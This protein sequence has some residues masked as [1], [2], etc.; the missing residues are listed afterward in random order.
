MASSSQRVVVNIDGV[1]YA[2]DGRVAELVREIVKGAAKLM[3]G[4][5]VLKAS[6]RGHDVKCTVEEDLN[7]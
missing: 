4:T 2:L 7:N 5:K 1:D 3:N 6:L